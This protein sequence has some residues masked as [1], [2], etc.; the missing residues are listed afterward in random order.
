MFVNLKQLNYSYLYL[1][2][3]QGRLFKRFHS[4]RSYPDWIK[5]YKLVVL[6][7]SHYLILDFIWIKTFSLCCSKLLGRIGTH[8]IQ[9]AWII[10]IPGE[11]WI[12]CGFQEQNVIN[13]T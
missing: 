8:L 6:I 13:L 4:D 5:S 3:Q 7:R 2:E 9:K 11:V 12:Q 10:L 1:E